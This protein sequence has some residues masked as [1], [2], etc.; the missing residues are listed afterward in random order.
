MSKKVNIIIFGGSGHWAE[1]NH[2]PAILSLKKKT[3]DVRVVAI[4]DP[5]DPYSTDSAH[6]A[7]G[8]SNL[9]AILESDRPEWINSNAFDNEELMAYLS[10][11]ADK[12]G[13]N[14]AIISTNPTQHFRYAL[15]AAQRSVAVICDKPLVVTRDASWRSDQALKIDRQFKDLTSAIEAGG[16]PSHR[17]FVV[18]LRR[19]ALRPF[20]QMADE[21]SHVYKKYEQPITHMNLLVNGG[22]HRYPKEYLKGGAHGFVEGIGSLS[23][24]SYHYLDV[25]AWYIKLAPGN[26]KKVGISVQY[27]RR[28]KDY[29]KSHAYKQL[30]ELNNE[31]AESVEVTNIPESVLNAEL[32]FSLH[33]TFYDENNLPVADVNYIYASTSFSPRKAKYSEDILD[34]ANSKGGGR[35]SQIFMDIHQGVMQNWQL[36]KN[37]EVFDGNEIEVTHRMHPEIGAKSERLVYGDAYE[38]KINPMSLVEDFLLSTADERSSNQEL[39]DIHSQQLSQRLFSLSYQKIADEFEGNTDELVFNISDLL[40]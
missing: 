32:D 4:C 7:V 23:H 12:S 2:Y 30:L 31:S 24:S 13:I 5:I 39:Q 40:D 10:E 33:Y 25:I 1:Q 27:V 16:L 35:M 22:V 36:I 3:D 9:A 37:D 34:H 15:W 18:P 29:L 20:T 11:V 19:R 8:R 21:I 6:Y 17:A 14:A 28:V 26:I 38:E